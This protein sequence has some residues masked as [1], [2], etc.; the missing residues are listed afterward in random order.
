MQTTRG[1]VD[2]IAGKGLLALAVKGRRKVK[3]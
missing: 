2:D 1:L 3:P